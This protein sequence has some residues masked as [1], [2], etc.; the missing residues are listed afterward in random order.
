MQFKYE[1]V[2]QRSVQ[3]RCKAARH[4][5][6]MLTLI[7]TL[8]IALMARFRFRI[9]PGNVC[10]YFLSI[11]ATQAAPMMNTALHIT[12]VKLSPGNV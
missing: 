5:V 12:P 1:N 6:D 4:E 7:V 3:Y 11:S 8:L 9:E 10:S 2:H